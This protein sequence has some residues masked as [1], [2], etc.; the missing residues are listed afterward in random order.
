MK[1]L[2]IRGFDKALEKELRALAR[3]E[4]I[5][6]SRATVDLLR[7]A[8][9]LGGHRT[10]RNVVGSSLDALIGTWSAAHAKAFQHA[11]E[12]FARVDASMWK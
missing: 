2:T 6:L 3:K 5:S 9:G 8:T 1:Q 10:R 11:I 7:Q 4:G 12:D